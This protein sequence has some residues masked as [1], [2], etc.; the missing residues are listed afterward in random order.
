VRLRT[1]QTAQ[2]FVPVEQEDTVIEHL[3]Q[4]ERNYRD[5]LEY[6][7]W[8][9]SSAATDY[10]SNSWARGLLEAADLPLPA[11]PSQMQYRY[12][13]WMTPVPRQYFQ[14]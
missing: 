11:F 6:W 4:L 13:G 9:E 8:P 1:P 3:L 5:N 2:I 12:P 10:N 14:Q 7:C